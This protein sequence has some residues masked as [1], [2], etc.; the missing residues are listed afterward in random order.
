MIPKAELHAHLEGT[1]GPDL[2]R[3]L[4]A[5]NDMSLPDGLLDDHGG[6]EW[7]GFL[8]FLRAYDAA[9][10]VI[11]TPRDYRDVTYEYLVGCARD[12][13]I[14]AEVM[15]SPDHAAIAGMSYTDHLDGIAQ[16]IDDARAESGIEARI[17][18]TCVRHFGVEKAL[19]VARAT[20]RH[21][22][23]LV[24]GFGMGG[25]EAGYPPGPFA[26]VFRIAHEEAGLACNVHAG[27]FG[28]P[29]SIRAALDLPVS[30]IGHGVRAIEDPSL[31]AELAES[32]IVLEVCPTS[33]VAT[34]VFP[35]YAEHPLPKLIAAGIR[36]TLSSDDPPYFHTTIGRE[37]DLAAEHFGFDED[38]LMAMTRNSIAAAFVDQ[39]TRQR[40]LARLPY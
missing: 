20:V 25:D 35:S 24:T 11:R 2:V 9:S 28:G 40:L 39:E 33:N 7:T 14:Y 22:H 34:G 3:R 18:V 19:D 36:V 17:I 29:D 13:A 10:S 1:A 23:R 8:D 30:R 26:E 38:A 5:R 16:G 12:G 31:M 6:F 32:G 4:A 27:E 15:S 37:Y 21:P